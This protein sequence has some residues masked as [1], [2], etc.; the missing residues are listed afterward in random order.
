MIRLLVAD[1]APD[2]RELVRALL[3][4]RSQIEIVGEAA[5]GVEAVELARELEP[6]VILMDVEM[7]GVDGIAATREIREH[8]RGAR[9][10]AFAGSDDTRTVMAM[11][12]AGA[13]AYCV[14]GARAWEL[15]RAV[16]GA[17]DPL[18]RLAQALARSLGESV[19]AEL[20]A[21]E[22]ADLTGAVLATVAFLSPAGVLRGAGTTGNPQGGASRIASGAARRA[23]DEREPVRMGEA[24]AL[25]L[26]VDG[27]PVGAVAVVGA[28]AEVDLGM[29]A[30]MAD[31]AAASVASER[32]L[33]LSREEARRDS[34]TG[35]AN[36]R[37]FDEELEHAEAAGR[38]VALALVDLDDFKRVND[39]RGHAA[40]DDVLRR[41]AVVL[42]RSVR[43]GEE[44]QHT[45]AA[46]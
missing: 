45:D 17:G 16:V 25:P 44:W 14:K 42:R 19:K 13:S 23:L 37:A 31:L 41:V 43:A 12:E 5:N 20:F 18:V 28:A 3:A 9:V 15:E 34:L 46:P 36:R 8:V 27:A 39:T 30:A 24:L 4:D 35:L 11:I 6:D 7:P 29:L 1:D 10:V 21:R 33:A 22:V 2:S 38:P 32:T 26:L 40:G